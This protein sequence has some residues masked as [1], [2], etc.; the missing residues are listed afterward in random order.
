VLILDE[1]TN[2]LDIPTLDVLEESLEEFPGAL[3]LVTHDRYLLDRLSTELLALDGCGNANLYADFAQWERAREKAAALAEAAAASKKAAVA[4]RPRPASSAKGLTWKEQVELQEMEERI[5]AA[6]SDVEACHARVGDPAVMND[7]VQLREWCDKL[8]E[9]QARVDALY[10]RWA[11]LEA[12][13]D[14]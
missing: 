8:H 1:P 2:D 7:H 3:V 12:K 10:A 4:R 6:E 13:R 14:A 5:L 11:E 9:A